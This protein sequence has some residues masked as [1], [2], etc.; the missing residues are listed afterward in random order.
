MIKKK[1]KIMR[2]LIFISKLGKDY[3]CLLAD[4]IGCALIPNRCQ[5]MQYKSEFTARSFFESH[6]LWTYTNI[7]GKCSNYSDTNNIKSSY[8]GKFDFFSHG[9]VD[10]NNFFILK[11][12]H[13]NVHFKQ[14]QFYHVQSRTFN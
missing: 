11:P 1:K 13:D 14:N 2:I 9:Q 12:K 4:V 8:P 7:Y 6:T 5:R 3:N 10:L